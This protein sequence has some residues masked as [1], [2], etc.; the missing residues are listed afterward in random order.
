MAPA[1]APLRAGL[2]TSGVVTTGFAIA[3]GVFGV[4]ALNAKS[5]F[6]KQLAKIRNSKDNVDSARSTMKT[7]AHLTD[8]F[9]AATLISGGVA[10]YFLLSDP[11]PKKLSETKRSLALAPTVG[12]LLLHGEW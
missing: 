12:G 10:M 8:A 3:T 9:G 5:D 4:M 6:N 1:K 2:I 7:Y 11:A